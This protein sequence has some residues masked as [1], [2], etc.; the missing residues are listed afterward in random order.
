MTGKK[1]NVPSKPVKEITSEVQA[2]IDLGRRQG[3]VTYDDILVHFPDAEQSLDQVDDLHEVL[4][5]QN[6]EIVEVPADTA[7]EEPAPEAEA[8]APAP[9]VSVDDPVR[10]YL[11]QIGEMPILTRE[12]EVALAQKIER[13]DGQAK[14]KMIEANLRL[15]VS[16]A[17]RYQG[18]GMPLPDLI[19]A[20]NLG[21]IR[22]V[23]HFD[24]RKGY[25]FSTYATWW[26]RQAILRALDDTARTIRLPVHMKEALSKLV[27]ASRKLRQALGRE[28]TT[29]EIAAEMNL[30]VER[31]R[32]MQEITRRPISLDLVVGEE[33]ETRLGDF[34][35]DSSGPEPV[36]AISAED[37]KTQLQDILE[38]LSPRER[39]VLTLRFGLE[40]GRPRTLEEVGQS[41]G[42]TRERIRQ[43][44]SKALRKLRHPIRK[45][46]LEDFLD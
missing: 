46:L 3:Y 26:I 11:N 35:E 43:I 10:R 2:L 45:K 28:P 41:F 31:I 36:E 38:T 1:K 40:D 42:V 39:E 8:P 12:Q 18:R 5:A 4:A 22:A 32:E 29:D 13:A 17:R 14:K 23:G 15:V 30:P 19:Q 7:P 20:G 33:G 27:R 37:L 34:I 9:G 21:L 16:V 6:I 25:K 44:E 24:W